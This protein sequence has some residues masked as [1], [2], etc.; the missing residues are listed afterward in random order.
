MEI[1]RRFWIEKAPALQK[2]REKR[3]I[4]QGYCN[5]P[6]NK[7]KIRI[8][9][10]VYENKKKTEYIKTIKHGKWLVREEIESK[11]TAQTRKQLRTEAQKIS[12]S[13][14]RYFLPYKKNTIELNIFHE[15]LEGLILAE[16]EFDSIEESKT[17]KIPARFGPEITEYKESTSHYLAKHGKSDLEKIVKPYEQRVH[18]DLAN[19]YDHEASKYASTRKKVRPEAPMLIDAV[20][21]N[22]KDSIKIIELWCGSGRFLEQLI[23]IKDKKIEYIG[24]DISEWL[25]TEA[26][27]IKTPKNITTQFIK[28]DMLS[29]LKTLEQESCDII[30]WIASIQH[31]TNT[32]NRILCTKYSYRALHYWGSLI[33]SNR[34]FSLRFL[35]KYRRALVET[36]KNMLFSKENKEWNS[37]LLPRKTNGKTFKRFYHIFTKN[38]ISEILQKAW[39]MITTLN[40]V[41]KEGTLSD[42]W[43]EATNT[44]C[45]GEK[46][47]FT[48]ISDENVAS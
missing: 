30:V 19:F 42:N 25:L 35:K 28:T 37:L 48:E 39:F 41:T 29:F 27:K 18:E 4:L 6:E 43:K 1:E 32:K 38:E 8:R 46:K 12:L 36:A 47:I 33:L 13:K 11:M 34:S 40:Y 16:V 31:L 26:K 17:F 22:T 9:K 44:I 15:N 10:I 14:T 5:D 24:I 20:Q 45:I 7:E 21:R 2:K 3:E 23:E